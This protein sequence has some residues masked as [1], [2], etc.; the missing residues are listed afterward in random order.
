MFAEQDF[1]TSRDP[2]ASANEDTFGWT[3][4]ISGGIDRG[5]WIHW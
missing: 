2:G 4:K 5:K 1:E 3:T